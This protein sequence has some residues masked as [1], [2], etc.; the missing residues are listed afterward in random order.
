METWGNFVV[1]W[2]P[3]S[4]QRRSAIDISTILLAVK[5]IIPLKYYFITICRASK[6]VCKSQFKNLVF[7]L[8]Y[9]IYCYNLAIIGNYFNLPQNNVAPCKVSYS[10]NWIFFFFFFF[11]LIDQESSVSLI[12]LSGQFQWGKICS[13]RVFWKSLLKETCNWVCIIFPQITEKI[14]TKDIFHWLELI[15]EIPCFL[16]IFSVRKTTT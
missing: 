9:L 7:E 8:F 10:L 5:T 3:W 2:N 1:S 13:L 6:T 12:L 11:F 4:C 16:Q 15:T 14:P